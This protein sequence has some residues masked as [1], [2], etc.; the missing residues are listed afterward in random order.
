MVLTKFRLPNFT[1]VLRI[2]QETEHHSDEVRRLRPTACAA[3]AAQDKLRPTGYDTLKGKWKQAIGKA[4]FV[5]AENKAMLKVSFFGPFYS[6]YNVLAI[7]SN[8]QYALIAG[9]NLRYLWI[10]SR[11]TSIPGDI[12]EQY[13]NIARSNGYNTDNLLWI[14]QEHSK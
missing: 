4:K 10:L 3:F 2:G 1:L 13:L 12:K 11:N 5:G 14:K 6:G 7:D 8:Y 9:A